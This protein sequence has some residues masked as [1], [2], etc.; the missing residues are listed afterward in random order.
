MHPCETHRDL[1]I[2]HM[3]NCLLT[4]MPA[5][6]PLPTLPPWGPHV[7]A[8]RPAH[9]F[10]LPPFPLSVQMS[11]VAPPAVPQPDQDEGGPQ[12][13]RRRAGG[14]G[15]IGLH[16]ARASIPNL[17]LSTCALLLPTQLSYLWT[18]VVHSCPSS[19]MIICRHDALEINSAD[20]DFFEAIRAL[21]SASTVGNNPKAYLGVKKTI[22][23]ATSDAQLLDHR[24]HTDRGPPLE[25]M[26]EAFASFSQDA[27]TCVPG[28]A[29]CTLTRQLVELVSQVG[30]GDISLV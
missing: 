10:F 5:P 4:W 16:V 29:A 8:C 6:Y 30:V 1:I 19:C 9:P 7:N 14:E 18:C 22:A 3:C 11:A 15:G 23:A 27:C 2:L 21:P 12:A 24:P 26:C 25:I 20:N 17:R 13:K 28:L